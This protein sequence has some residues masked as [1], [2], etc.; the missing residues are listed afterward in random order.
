VIFNLP[1]SRKKYST[2]NHLQ[3]KY[4]SSVTLVKDFTECKKV[5]VEC[6]GHSAK[7]GSP[8]VFARITLYRE[9]VARQILLCRALVYAECLAFNRGCLCRVS[10]S[11]ESDTCFA[12][13][14]IN[15]TRQRD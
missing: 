4:L 7:N 14:P 8:V 1:S 5:F 12:K 2:K 6:L 9:L 3:I 10:L 11:I 13:C 15:Y